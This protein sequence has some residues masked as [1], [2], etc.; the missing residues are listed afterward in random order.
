MRISNISLPHPILGLKDDIKGNFT[1]APIVN[2]GKADIAIEIQ[3]LVSNST[4]EEL[5]RDNKCGYCVELNCQ[6]T[7]YRKSFIFV[8]KDFKIEISANELSG[9]V[10]VQVFMVA[11]DQ[12]TNYHPTGINLDYMDHQFKL[13]K[14]DVIGYGGSFVFIVEK[15]YRNLKKLASFIVI[16]KNDDFDQGPVAYDLNGDRILVKLGKKEFEKSKLLQNFPN[17]PAIFHTAIIYP[18]LMHAISSLFK[19][20][21]SYGENMWS[22]YINQI[23]E[24]NDELRELDRNDPDS[25]VKAAQAILK[26]PLTRTLFAI[27]K[28]E[29]SASEDPDYIEE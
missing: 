15:S 11:L 27:Q 3:V 26:D 5:I 22:V 16:E 1:I 29:E 7:L 25:A 24:S 20:L 6:N 12:I 17:I 8:D 14:G 2:L 21:D 23:L 10:D 4:I 18:A 28:L 9:K 13:K 19:D